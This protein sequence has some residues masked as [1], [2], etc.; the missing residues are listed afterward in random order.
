[1]TGLW[2]HLVTLAQRPHDI[3]FAAQLPHGALRV[4]V[5]GERGTRPAGG[6]RL[7]RGPQAVPVT[8][9]TA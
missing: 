7:L 6:R 4:F 8:T 1:M 5:M 2:R 3:D 9:G